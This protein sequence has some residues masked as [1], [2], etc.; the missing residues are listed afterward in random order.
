MKM[1]KQ[2]HPWTRALIALGL[3]TAQSIESSRI[4]TYRES[5]RPVTIPVTSGRISDDEEE[6]VCS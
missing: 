3:V 6:A 2:Y 5:L 4:E 1:E